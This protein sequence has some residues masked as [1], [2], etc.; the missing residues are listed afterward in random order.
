MIKAT[1]KHQK[2]ASGFSHCLEPLASDNFSSFEWRVLRKFSSSTHFGPFS[3][4]LLFTV[5]CR[6]TSPQVLSSPPTWHWDDY[7]T[8]IH[9]F[10][11]TSF[12]S[13][14]F[15]WFFSGL[16]LL[17]LQRPEWL[18][19]LICAEV[20]LSWKSQTDKHQMFEGDTSQ[21]WLFWGSTS[22]QIWKMKNISCCRSS[23]IFI[24]SEDVS[25]SQHPPSVS[26]NS[27]LKLNLQETNR[28]RKIK[29]PDS[30]KHE[31]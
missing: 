19:D 9:M 14:W 12:L 27:L 28:S 11:C 10:F 3:S 7:V 1:W 29:L 2:L 16:W 17:D 24:W 8:F 15:L 21:F 18:P 6:D 20:N 25:P 31:S 4:H 5:H 26:C 13:L 22:S 23:E 30:R